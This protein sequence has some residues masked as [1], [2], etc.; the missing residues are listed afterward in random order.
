MV[1]KGKMDIE[2]AKTWSDAEKM[3]A[4]R[5]LESNDSL[6]RSAIEQ[7]NRTVKK[8]FII[9]IISIT[10]LVVTNSCWLYVFQSYEYV[11]QDGNGVNNINSGTQGDLL[12]GAES[13]N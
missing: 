13:E 6:A 8:W 3:I 12:N 1:D 2:S 7:A 9:A 11:S 4:E 10:A 5:L